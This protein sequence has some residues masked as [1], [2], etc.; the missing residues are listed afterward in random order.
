MQ[1]QSS[2]DALLVSP[3][4]RKD[5]LLQDWAVN[6][7]RH[8]IQF[9]L[10]L[11]RAAQAARSPFNVKSKRLA[12]PVLLAYLIYSEFMCG[13][14][15]PV[16][17]IV[18]PRLQISHGFGIV[19]NERSL[20]GSDVVLRHGTTI[21][22]NGFENSCPQ[23]GNHVSIGVGAIILGGISVGDGARIKAG[24]LVTKNIPPRIDNT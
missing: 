17:T 20:I 6:S 22:N 12:K 21:G 9:L 11:F 7:G 4:F 1:N 5:W 10:F 23:I 3:R 19:I 8:K 14:E 24:E 18:G 13:I 15:I 16:K 2:H